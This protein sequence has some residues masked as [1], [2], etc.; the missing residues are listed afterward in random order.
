MLGR[1]GKHLS[2][3]EDCWHVVV[4]FGNGLAEMAIASRNIASLPPLASTLGSAKHRGA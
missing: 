1:I 4:G 2:S 3:R